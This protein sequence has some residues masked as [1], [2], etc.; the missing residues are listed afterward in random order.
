MNRVRPLDPAASPRAPRIAER[1]RH[2]GVCRTQVT[3]RQVS[4]CN[5]LLRPTKCPTVAG[6]CRGI[7]AVMPPAVPGSSLPAAPGQAPDTT[8]AAGWR[9]ARTGS[10]PRICWC[11][12][13]VPGSAPSSSTS[14]A[15]RRWPN[16]ISPG[17]GQLP[18]RRIGPPGLPA[19]YAGITGTRQAVPR[20]TVRYSPTRISSPRKERMHD[21]CGHGLLVSFSASCASPRTCRC[22]LAATPFRGCRHCGR[23]R[24]CAGIVGSR[25][26]RRSHTAPRNRHPSWPGVVHI[27]RGRPVAYPFTHA[28]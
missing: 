2:G 9:A 22:H 17:I 10:A 18:P 19:L 21:L 26:R 13:S 3:G 20:I 25:G 11:S 12:S 8:S 28:P 23:D 1:R 5:S 24:Q 27:G 6:N 16:S 4:S 15:R 7:T 14:I